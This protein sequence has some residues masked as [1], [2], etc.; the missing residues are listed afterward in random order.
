MANRAEYSTEG[1]FV[2]ATIREGNTQ[3][4][5][6]CCILD[7]DSPSYPPDDSE[8]RQCGCYLCT[9]DLLSAAEQRLKVLE[10][11]EMSIVIEPTDA[12]A[13]ATGKGRLLLN[14]YGVRCYEAGRSEVRS[15]LSS[16]MSEREDPC[17][18]RGVD[19]PC[20]VAKALL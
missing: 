12:P 9:K 18:E 14:A 17:Y 7:C 13:D 20:D 4:D 2:D 15:K 3:R 10:Q 5:P 6:R 1:K 8:R 19:W 11:L 16:H